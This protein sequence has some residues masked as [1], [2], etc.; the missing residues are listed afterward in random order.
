MDE[1]I[2]V[3]VSLAALQDDK[4]LLVPHYH[5]D[6]GPVQWTIP[7]GRVHFGER[8]AEAALREF[9]EETGLEAEIGALL[10]VTQIVLPEKPWHSITITFAGRVSGGDLQAE[11]DHPYGAKMPRWFTAAEAAQ[12]PTH[13]QQT[14]KKALGIL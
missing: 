4:I 10:D 11:P 6:A 7:G 12:V 14:V 13:P 3:R 5:T 2:R 1:T 8:L 9:R